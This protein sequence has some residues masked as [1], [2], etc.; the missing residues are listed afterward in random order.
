MT[1]NQSGAG[2]PIISERRAGDPAWKSISES[3]RALESHLGDPGQPEVAFSFAQALQ[4]D[5]REEYP[6]AAQ[7]GID[8][9]DL[10]EFLIPVDLGGRLRTAEELLAL[11]RVVAR[12]DLTVAISFG[13]NL[14]AALPVWIAGTPSQRQSVV[15]ILRSHRGMALAV[16]ERGHGSDVLANG[17][18]ADPVDE[19]FRLSGEK[20]LILNA[21]RSAAMVVFARTRRSG[22]PRCSSLF[23]LDK[24]RL[25]PTGWEPLLRESTLGLRGADVSG[26]RFRSCTVPRD[27]MVGPPGRA[28][29][30]L[31]LTLAV[32]RTLCAALALGAADTALRI[33][34]GF[35][36]RRRLYGQAVVDIPHARFL[37]V[38]VFLD[39]LACDCVTSAAIRAMQRPG[40][41]VAFWSALVKYYVP[42]VIERAVHDLSVVLGA[43]FYLRREQPCGMFQKILRDLAIVSVFEGSTV[44]N[45]G[46]LS[47]QL[48]RRPLCHAGSSLDEERIHELYDLGRSQSPFSPC[49]LRLRPLTTDPAIAGLPTAEALEFD[50]RDRCRQTSIEARKSILE[51]VLRLRERVSSWERAF[52]PARHRYDSRP[53][54]MTPELA[55][56]VE[57]YCRLHAAAACFHTW[58]QNGPSCG[59]FLGRGDW[60]VLCLKRLLADDRYTIGGAAPWITSVT[61][62]LVDRYD[63]NR[64]YSIIPH[65][66]A[67]RSVPKNGTPHAIS[68]EPC[69]ETA[70]RIEGL[71]AIKSQDYGNE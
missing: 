14:L 59:G 70:L 60:L 39:C 27:T 56:Q 24:E 67:T 1:T 63:S 29:E 44:V 28:Y 33:A 55:G 16:T 8:T 36:L 41:P 11:I 61:D 49:S 40:E 37:L 64:L 20:W 5:E 22:G 3:V 51:D 62:E 9:W 32:T 25:D 17:F 43:R 12:R 31:Q 52:E 30:T 57:R 34:V 13:A 7:S 26:V 35:A 21:Q 18:R 65:Q 71:L 6:L 23:L 38:G 50:L 68:D 4:H 10:A 53:H 47:S 69:H 19:G 42:T 15:E 48:A 58:S 54:A 66:L 2:R 45:L 46:I